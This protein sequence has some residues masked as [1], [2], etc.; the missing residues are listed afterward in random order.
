MRLDISNSNFS[1]DV[2][3]DENRVLTASFISEKIKDALRNK[4]KSTS[5]FSSFDSNNDYSDDE[6]Q[7]KFLSAV[8]SARS[9]YSKMIE[10]GELDN[11]TTFEQH[12][13]FLFQGLLGEG[14]NG[15][16]VDNNL[17][18]YAYDNFGS[19]DELV[20]SIRIALEEN[21]DVLDEDDISVDSVMDE[22]KDG[23]LDLDDSIRFIIEEEIINSD[24]SSFKDLYS[25]IGNIP[26]IYVPDAE[27]L[28]SEDSQITMG[29][30]SVAELVFPDDNFL[31]LLR[32]VNITP[33]AFVKEIKT[34][35]G[36]DLL[37]PLN[38]EDSENYE[39][40]KE[41][42][43]LKTSEIGLNPKMN[44]AISPSE[45]IETLENASSSYVTPC[46]AISLD[47]QTI[48]NMNS[49]QD[50][51]VTQGGLIGV[52]DFISG[53]GCVEPSSG[54]VVLSANLDNWTQADG[55]ECF[56]SYNFNDVYGFSLDAFNGDFNL[57]EKESSP[58]YSFDSPGM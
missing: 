23:S 20:D 27:K 11:E 2:E 53:S 3:I 30:Y 12:V 25:S 49:D 42:C 32:L 51:V 56:G 1:F 6:S 43:A 54:P 29:G 33:Q 13:G 8:K 21:Q 38:S 24:T 39:K 48:I 28:Y 4:V 41:F 36:V 10:S 15:Y 55:P 35:K 14:G 19:S 52:H 18:E 44:S 47:P 46:F 5:Y 17:Y 50:L 57:V 26:M 45:L 58:Q 7:G 9:T 22:L 31:D 40:W 37:N 16:I 34:Q